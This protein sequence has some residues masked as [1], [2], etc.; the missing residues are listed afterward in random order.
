MK[1]FKIHPVYINIVYHLLIGY[2]A[3]R[4]GWKN[5]SD[6]YSVMILEKLLQTI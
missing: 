2:R 1:T 3:V 5:N 6:W 4:V